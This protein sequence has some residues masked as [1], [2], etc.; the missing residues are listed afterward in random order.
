[1]EVAVDVG[2]DAVF[3]GSQ[4]MSA[5]VMVV[6]VASMVQTN[7][8]M[9]IAMVMVMLMLIL[10]LMLVL[11]LLLSL[12]LTTRILLPIT[13]IRRRTQPESGAVTDHDRANLR[14][15]WMSPLSASLIASRYLSRASPSL[16]RLAEPQVNGLSATN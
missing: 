3:S 15:R 5:V 16:T 1:M 9:L 10:L 4:P 7:M 6:I 14:S 12:L 8:M 13:L 11:L 2:E